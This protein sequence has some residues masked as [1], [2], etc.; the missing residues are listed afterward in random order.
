MGEKSFASRKEQ[1]KPIGKIRVEA[2]RR[3]G[4]ERYA[5]VTRKSSMIKVTLS[6]VKYVVL[7]PNPLGSGPG[8]D[9]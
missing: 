7:N 4:A 1:D 3:V 2:S 5:I 8:G 6:T 9:G